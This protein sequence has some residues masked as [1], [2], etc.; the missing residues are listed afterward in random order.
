MIGGDGI[1]HGLQDHGFAGAR[2]RVDQAALA[3]A[4]RAEKIEHAARHVLFGGFHLEAA[5]RIKGRQ[6]VEEDFV[7]RN[8]RIFKID[9][10]DFDQREITLAIFGRADL[11]G[12]GVTGAKIELADLRRRN[13]DVVGAGKIVVFRRAEKTE[14]IGETFEDTFGEDQ[15]V[16]L[17]LGA[18]D[19]E[20]QLLFAHAAGARD[21]EFLGDLGEVGDVFFF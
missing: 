9:G 21:V 20:D 3:F 18:Q 7:A 6:V 16:L 1:G 19:L 4:H 5:L 8:F 17:R 2:R 14:S 15:S 10:F 11:A 12:D 13:I